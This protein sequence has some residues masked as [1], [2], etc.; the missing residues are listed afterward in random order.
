[1]LFLAVSGPAFLLGLFFL[2]PFARH[3]TDPFWRRNLVIGVTVIGA[4]LALTGLI[5]GNV[6]GAFLLPYGAL[7]ALL[8]LLYLWAAVGLFGSSADM[9]YRVALALGVLGALAIAV[10]VIRSFVV[11]RYLVPNGL[12]LI[13]V[14]LLY[15]LLSIGICSERQ[16]VVLARRELAAYFYSPIAYLVLFG[17]VVVTWVNYFFFVAF[18]KDQAIPEPILRDY[19]G[20]GFISFIA[21][22]FIVP[23]LTMRLLSE[24]QRTGTIE[25]MLTAPVNEIIVVL[26]KF[27][28]GLVFFLVVCLPLVLFL[29]PL[30]IEGGKPFDVL[31]LV[32]FFLALLCSGA[33]FVSMGLF[34]SSLTRNQIV[35]AVLTFMG[36]I[37]LIGFFIV[38]RSGIAG[39]NASAALR[40]FSFIHLWNDSLG[41]KLFLRDVVGH[42]SLAV[43]W[44][45]LTVKVIES[46]K[47]K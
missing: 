37:V 43:F 6:N 29:I 4:A 45:F 35:A 46:R 47:W 9:G 5:G 2:L 31:P 18:V 13:G 34:F 38:V 41:G 28:A 3:E 11:S 27:L 39:P 36:M 25:V 44:L 24:E 19:I 20:E 40:P 42:L 16:I 26:S 21:V 33:A 8:G 32:S 30:R 12:V 7:A 22:P 23:V 10:A 1:M 17:M 15:V 14:G